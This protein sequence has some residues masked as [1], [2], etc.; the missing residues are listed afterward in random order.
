MSH[1]ASRY[2]ARKSSPDKTNIRTEKENIV[3]AKCPR[4][5]GGSD[6]QAQQQQAEEEKE[7]AVVD[8]AREE[9]ILDGL[10]SARQSLQ[11]A[12]RRR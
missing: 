8:G 10:L 9:R 6:D 7:V 2:D 3:D 5:E 12:R 11:Q 1:E 4:V